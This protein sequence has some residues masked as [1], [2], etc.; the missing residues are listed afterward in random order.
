MVG[1]VIAHEPFAMSAVLAS[2]DQLTAEPAPAD[3]LFA[4]GY[5]QWKDAHGGWFTISV[6]QSIEAMRQTLQQSRAH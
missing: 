5:K 4:E 6:A 1:G 3:P 2:V